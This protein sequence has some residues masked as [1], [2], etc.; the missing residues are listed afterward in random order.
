MTAQCGNVRSKCSRAPSM[1]LPS[2]P[3]PFVREPNS[4]PVVPGNAACS[5]AHGRTA[6]NSAGPPVARPHPVADA[7]GR[8]R[9][10]EQPAKARSAGM[11]GALS[12]S[13]NVREGSQNNDREVIVMDKSQRRRARDRDAKSPLPS[14]AVQAGRY[15]GGPTCVVGRTARYRSGRGIAKTGDSMN[16][17]GPVRVL[18]R[19]GVVVEMAAPA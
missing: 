16:G 12:A 15:H 13:H 6:A 17:H 11:I 14:E 2:R 19:N 9:G 5:I 3:R 7:Q 10:E 1:E 8:P 4:S 18:M